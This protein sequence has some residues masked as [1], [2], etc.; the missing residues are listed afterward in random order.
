MPDEYL[1][2]II[3]R[4]DGHPSPFDQQ[5]VVEYN[6]TRP[7]AAPNGD[8]MSFH[9]ECT[10]EQPRA[11][12]FA[13]QPDAAAYWRQ[14]SN[15]PGSYNMPLTG[16]TVIIEPADEESIISLPDADTCERIYMQ[17]LR[18]RDWQGVESALRVL[19]VVDPHRAERLIEVSRLGIALREAG[20]DISGLRD[21]EGS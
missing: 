12:R 9:L 11:R 7:G 20:V 10:A 16:F 4:A 18:Q 17:A 2:K 15:S 6:P 8:A 14:Q 13:T 1:L 21:E 19:A 3:S 5:W